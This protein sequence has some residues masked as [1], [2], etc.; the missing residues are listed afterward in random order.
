MNRIV[1]V[2]SSFDEIDW[3]VRLINKQSNHNAFNDLNNNWQ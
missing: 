2:N 1:V 3:S